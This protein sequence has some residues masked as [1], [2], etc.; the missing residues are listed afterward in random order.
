MRGRV[1]NLLEYEGSNVESLDETEEE[2]CLFAPPHLLRRY[3]NISFYF[4]KVDKSCE[5]QLKNYLTE[6][7]LSR[8]TCL[9][10][11]GNLELADLRIL[12][13]YFPHH[14]EISVKLTL[15]IKKRELMAEKRSRNIIESFDLVL[16]NLISQLRKLESVMHD[17]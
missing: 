1:E 11:H 5:E 12:V 2:V 9:L 17:K 4:Q 16:D 13:E 15:S 14:N 6:E 3:M 8:L 7:K 10:R